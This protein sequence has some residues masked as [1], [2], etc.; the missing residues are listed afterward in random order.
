[1][2]GRR[3]D[4]I[5]FDDYGRQYAVLMDASNGAIPAFGFQP[6]LGETQ[7]FRPPTGLRLRKAILQHLT[8]SFK[9]EILCATADAPAFTGQIKLVTLPD[10]EDGE[11]AT[12]KVLYTVYERQF[13]PPKVPEQP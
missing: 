10:F 5:Y 3:S 9:R 4:F 2:A 8:K 7:L 13:N 11:D 12:F 1:M 6:Y